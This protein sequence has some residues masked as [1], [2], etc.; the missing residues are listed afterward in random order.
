MKTVLQVSLVVVL[1]V[2]ETAVPGLVLSSYPATQR[3]GK[4]QVIAADQMLINRVVI[5]NPE[6]RIAQLLTPL[7]ISLHFTYTRCNKKYLRI[8]PDLIIGLQQLFVEHKELKEASSRLHLRIPR[9]SRRT[10]MLENAFQQL[11]VRNLSAFRLSQ[12]A[13][14]NSPA[15]FL[16]AT[17]SKNYLFRDVQAAHNDFVPQ[18]ITQK[19][20]PTPISLKNKVLYP[21]GRINRYLHTRRGIICTTKI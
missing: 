19:L 12:V 18:P 16:R 17:M 13:R 4:P 8:K 7:A 14:K 6:I 20:P 10:T 3:R 21:I 9:K 2:S 15:G 1:V 5:V 11:S